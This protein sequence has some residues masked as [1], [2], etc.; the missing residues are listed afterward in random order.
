[1]TAA[2]ITTATIG[3]QIETGRE[4]PPP[5]AAQLR[6]GAWSHASHG[7]ALGDRSF[8]GLDNAPRRR[9]TSVPMVPTRAG[10]D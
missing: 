3:I 8:F 7:K 6:E 9:F 2:T 10:G 5:E 4:P 1:M